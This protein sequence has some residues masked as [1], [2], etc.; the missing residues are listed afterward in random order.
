MLLLT[1]AACTHM[2]A[3]SLWL[4]YKAV[5]G[6]T[7]YASLQESR[8]LPEQVRKHGTCGTCISHLGEVRVLRCCMQAAM[9]RLGT[10][11]QGLTQEASVL[12]V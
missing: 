2:H 12:L 10:T 3:C 11:I 4:I 7:V 8:Q 1:T 6:C 9:H 5:Y